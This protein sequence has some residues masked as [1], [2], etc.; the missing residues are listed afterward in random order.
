MGGGREAGREGLN[1]DKTKTLTMYM[2]AFV[3]IGMNVFNCSGSNTEQN[4]L[5]LKLTVCISST[6]VIHSK[7]EYCTITFNSFTVLYLPGAL[8]RIADQCHNMSNEIVFG[9]GGLCVF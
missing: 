8:R 4:V 1:T 9:I 3:S 2:V 6:I 7:P 5:A